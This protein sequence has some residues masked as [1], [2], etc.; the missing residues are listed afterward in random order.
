MARERND[1]NDPAGIEIFGKQSDSG[2]SHGRL[3]AVEM[4]DLVR[5]QRKRHLA[6]TVLLANATKC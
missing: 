1:R 6:R 2:G 3:R 4:A 5:N